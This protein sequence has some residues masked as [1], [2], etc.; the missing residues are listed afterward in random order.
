[1]ATMK[2]IIFATEQARVKLAP[3]N[4]RR[5]PMGTLPVNEGI[6]MSACTLADQ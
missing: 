3:M 6:A 4:L 1:V 2:R 5:A